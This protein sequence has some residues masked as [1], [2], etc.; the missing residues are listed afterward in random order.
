MSRKFLIATAI[1]LSSAFVPFIS[2]AETSGTTTQTEMPKDNWLNTMTPMLPDL[3]CKGFIQDADLKKRFDEIQM[4]YEKCVSLIPDSAKKCQDQIYSSIPDKINS[5]TAGTW[6]R[7][8]GEC[9]GRDF[10]EKYLVQ[11]S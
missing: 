8:L 10:A 5:E 1:A 3:I 9:I 4:T 6:G 11:K 2:N 7:T